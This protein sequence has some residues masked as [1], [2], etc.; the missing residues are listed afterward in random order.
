[1][2]KLYF[3][4]ILL[5][6]FS[7]GSKKKADETEVIVF[8][9]ASL[10]DVVSQ[11]AANFEREKSIKT[12]LNFAAS[13]T[14]ALQID[15]GADADVYLSANKSWRDFLVEKEKS[16]E[17]AVFTKNRL[18]LISPLDKTFQFEKVD[19]L[20][21]HVEGKI[22]IGDPGYVPAGKYAMQVLA[23]YRLDLKTKLFHNQNVRTAL[24]M[25]ELGEADLG[26]VYE[27]DAL[28][29]KKVNIIYSFPQESYK[30]VEYYQMLISNKN[31]AKEFY[32]YLYSA[33]TKEILTEYSFTY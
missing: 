31:L 7:C 3:L 11:L 27:T 6:F 20:L 17:T 33:K 12:K 24:M 21:M 10:T 9:A 30:P 25:V 4:F 18:V 32:D 13:G 1:M 8:A 19:S 14:L 26:I 16:K 22:A 15:Q 5:F 28:Q 2:K 23:Y 29:S